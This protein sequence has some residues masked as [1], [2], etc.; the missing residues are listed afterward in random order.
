MID[1][2]KALFDQPE[3]PQPSSVPMTL[4]DIK[5]QFKTYIGLVQDMARE[6]DT[7]NVDCP[8]AQTSAVELGGSAKRLIKNIEAKREEV[9]S[10]ARQFV[11]SVNSFCKI[12]T[13]K[14]KH[15]TNVLE[16]KLTTYRTMQ[17]L[18]RRK[19]EE[20]ARK[21]TEELQKRLNEEAKEAGVEAPIAVTPIMPEA[22]PT[23]KT[24]TGVTAYGRKKWKAD[25]VD[26][27]QVPREY[28]S[29][30]MKK[31]NAAVKGGIRSIPGVKIFEDS[32]T[33][34]RT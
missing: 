26:E 7:I 16:G 27:A 4:E 10:E 24:E 5:P 33:V 1:M 34:F 8:D 18:E 20:A 28:C 12:F 31:I 17:E 30:D 29:S 19:Q 23:V 13:E 22:K 32:T 2:S 9:T 6:A 25:I 15:A 11:S 21:A 3:E 14:L